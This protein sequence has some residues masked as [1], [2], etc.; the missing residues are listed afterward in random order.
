MLSDS[1][2]CGRGQL[3]SHNVG[4]VVHCKNRPSQATELPGIGMSAD[5]AD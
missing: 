3:Y 5:A 4:W 1:Q 2:P